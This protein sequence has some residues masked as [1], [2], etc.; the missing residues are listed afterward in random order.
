LSEAFIH[1]KGGFSVDDQR[2]NNETA[3][4]DKALVVFGQFI[5]CLIFQTKRA[6]LTG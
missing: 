6:G 5:S 2:K 1:L 4:S 3:Q